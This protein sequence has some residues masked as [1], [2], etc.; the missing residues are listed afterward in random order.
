MSDPRLCDYH[1]TVVAVCTRLAHVDEETARRIA[2]D[3]ANACPE[4]SKKKETK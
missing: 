1:F 4:C 3:L 2:T